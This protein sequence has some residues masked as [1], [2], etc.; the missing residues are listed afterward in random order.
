MGINAAG[1]AKASPSAWSTQSITLTA[2]LAPGI[3][4][5]AFPAPR[6]PNPTKCSLAR[7]TPRWDFPAGIFQ[8]R[9]CCLTFLYQI[10]FPIKPHPSWNSYGSSA[11]AS[12]HAAP[13][14]AHLGLK[15]CCTTPK[16]CQVHSWEAAGAGPGRGN[17][18]IP[19]PSGFFAEEAALRKPGNNPLFPWS[20]YPWEFPGARI[21]ED[22]KDGLIKTNEFPI[23]VIIQVLC[24]AR[25]IKQQF[26]IN[27]NF[28]TDFDSR[29]I[30]KKS[31]QITQ[32]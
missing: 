1:V 17:R 18:R 11:P 25:W 7:A 14:P 27:N 32:I 21:P 13:L 2:N 31:S 29:E 9:H 5:G 10:E 15:S 28:L 19:V 12:Q 24:N 26:L 6:T 23:S 20:I 22:T 3:F 8:R 16:K 30:L 4:Q